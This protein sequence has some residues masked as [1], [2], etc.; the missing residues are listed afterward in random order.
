MLF[1]LTWL[2]AKDNPLAEKGNLLLSL[3][4]QAK[5]YWR[6]QH[7]KGITMIAS[8]QAKTLLSPVKPGTDNWFGLRYNLNLYRG[9]QHECI[10]CDSRS[11]CYEIKNFSDI[12]VKGNALE[13]LEKEIRS[14]RNRGTIGFG[15]MNDPYMPLEKE[16][17]LTRQALQIINRHHFPVHLITKSNLVV[18]DMDILQEIS[19]V[20]AAI[21]ITITTTDDALS[22][23]IEPGAP[24]SSERFRALKILSENG[25]YCGI[26][27]MP[28][29]PFITDQPENIEK[30]VHMAKENGAGYIL[31]AMG[32]TIREGQREY[33]YR[34]LDSRFP[35]LKDRYVKSFGLQYSCNATNYNR[36]WQVITQ[37]CHS[38][39]MPM[40]MEFYNARKANQLDLF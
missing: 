9:C 6:I 36:L 3:I 35:G 39:L 10:Y 27:L 32:M 18:R 17:K 30:L 7:N 25:I 2:T 19:R 23:L 28:V 24:V 34:Q 15:S 26:T 29:L 37:T 13:L 8:I 16:L 33:F 5:Y 40:N 11:T 14:K 4:G 12:L 21:S 20:Y 22:K 31:A 38:L 1:P